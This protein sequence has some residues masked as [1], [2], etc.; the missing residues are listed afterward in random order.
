MMGLT[1][2]SN[3]HDLFV[4]GINL[5]LRVRSDHPLRNIA[6]ALDLGF[7][8]DEVARFY[9][10]NGNPSVDP[11]VLVKMLLLLFLDDV[12]SERELMRII[13]ERLD[14]LWF[15]GY[16]IDDAIPNHSV[17]SKAR[18]RWGAE[19][20]ESI[21]V[22]TVQ[23][24]AQAGLIDGRKIHMDSSLI[25]ANASNNAVIQSSPELVKQIKEVFQKEERKLQCME[26]APSK[27]AAQEEASP[28]A[29]G[30]NTTRVNLSDP[31]AAI[32]A[33]P[34]KGVRA[35]YKSHRVV[36]DAHGV[37]TAVETTGGDV[38]D[39]QRLGALVG[40]HE[41]NA[42][43]SVGTVVADSGYG[44]TENFVA[45][46]QQG[47]RSHMASMA[48]TQEAARQNKGLF[49]EDQ[50]RYDARNDAY[51]CPAGHAMKPRRL[52]PTRRTRE[53]FL[54]KATCGGCSLRS[55]CTKSKASRTIQ[56]HEYQEA[57]TEARQQSGSVKARRDR[58]RRK[59]LMEGSFAD[60]ANNHGF[61]RARW[62]G[63][64]R[65][66]IQDYLIASVQNIRLLIARSGRK[67]TLHVAASILP[68]RYGQNAKAWASAS[69]PRSLH[70]HLCWQT[71]AF[72]A[73]T[74]RRH[75]RYEAANSVLQCGDSINE[76]SRTPFRQHAVKG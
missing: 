1:N 16:K 24:C 14:Y 37:V 59:H 9:G 69:I 47:I 72:R 40:L 35:R 23:Q 58:R 13:P 71:P 46:Q 4:P 36:D 18:K 65:Q 2:A 50:F 12:S 33:R 8:R 55:Q 43:Q 31:E 29:K 57:L 5:D 6:Q 39:G 17:L 49:H 48:A 66:S 44:T 7:V 75:P 61:K 19:V 22:R 3:Q 15:L 20:F 21:F 60:A 76:Q 54:P 51:V 30:V 45:C 26:A 70:G 10:R 68:S 38:A 63:L 34:G 74:A 32:V 52:H 67:P 42:G 28:A 64:W 25:D 56:R 27:A 62:R 53:Y 11:E 41:A 73:R